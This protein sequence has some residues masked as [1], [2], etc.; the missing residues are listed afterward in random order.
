ML[1]STTF[2]ALDQSHDEVR[3]LELVP[4]DEEDPIQCTQQII[5]LDDDDNLQ[6]SALSYVWGDKKEDR[7]VLINGEKFEVTDNLFDALR[8]IRKTRAPIRLWIDALCINQRTDVEKTHQV[9]MMRRI[10]AKCTTCYIWLGRIKGRQV[11]LDAARRAFRCIHYMSECHKTQQLPP[12][13]KTVSMQEEAGYGLHKMFDVPWWT[14][15][16]TVQ[17]AAIL[18]NCHLLWG[19]LEISWKLLVGAAVNL[20][21]GHVTN[22]QLR[23][24]GPLNH[25]TASIIWLERAR[26]DCTPARGT[27][28]IGMLFRFRGRRASDPRDKVYA[29]PGLISQT[30]TL[31]PSVPSCDYTLDVVTLYKRVTLDLILGQKLLVALVGRLEK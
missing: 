26:S 14:R 22:R 5:G 17:E 11:P 19:P 2:Q 10:Y 24:S 16:W 13:L 12:D 9:N 4:G 3:L 1:Q 18:R 27:A 20:G 28:P 29:V 8:Q 6:W 15:I 21:R 23:V 25:F 30:Q 31:L 7:Y